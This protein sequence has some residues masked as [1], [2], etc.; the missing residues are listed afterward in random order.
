ML[1]NSRIVTFL[2]WRSSEK[3]VEVAEHARQDAVAE[4]D[5]QRTDAKST[6]EQQRQDA[7]ASLESETKRADRANALADRSAK[8]AEETA[9]AAAQQLELGERAWVKVTEVKPR[10]NTPPVQSLSFQEVGDRKVP[11]L[12]YQVTFNYEIHLKILGRSPALNINVWPELYLALW[13]DN[14]N[15]AG[16]VVAEENRV[17]DEF[18][19]RKK[20]SKNAGTAAFPDETPVVYQGASA[21]VFEESK[22]HFSDAPGEYILPVLIGCVDYQFQSSGRHHQTR[23]VYEAFHAHEPRTRFFIVGS[24]ISANDLLLIRNESDDYAY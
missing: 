2:Q 18:A 14:V 17:C 1:D 11:R 21:L 8:A 13:G 16:K 6:L 20:E 4:A 23:F 19:K 5:R 24:G 22:V 15:Y 10:G 12:R 3:A 9:K 7:S